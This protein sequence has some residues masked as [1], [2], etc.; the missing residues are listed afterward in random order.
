MSILSTSPTST[1]H[2]D[3]KIAAALRD[4]NAA[5]LIQ[6]LHYWM[7]KK[8]VGVII[9]RSPHAERASSQFA[10]AP[11]ETGLR[12]EEIQ[13]RVKSRTIQAPEFD[14]G[15]TSLPPQRLT[16]CN[17]QNQV[18]SEQITRQINQDKIS[19]EVDYI[20]NK[21][22]QKQVEDLDSAGIPVNKTVVNLLKMYTPEQ[23]RGAIAL[24]KARKREQHIP[25]PSGYFVAALKGDWGG[26]QILAHSESEVEVDTAAVFRH[27]YDKRP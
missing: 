19:G 21:N 5:I 20:V 23:V 1:R 25:N 2:F 9:G 16:A 26:K 10:A 4:I 14:S 11:T 8:E 6:Q 3:M 22:W 7:N 27:W 12:E 18:K 13:K 24:V 15:V 17:G